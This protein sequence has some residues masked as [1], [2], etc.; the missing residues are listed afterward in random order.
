[1][2]NPLDVAFGIYSKISSSRYIPRRAVPLEFVLR[3]RSEQIPNPKSRVSLS[4]R[5][6][7]LGLNQIRLDWRMNGAERRS[8]RLMFQ[9]LKSEFE[10]LGIGE[11][12]PSEWLESDDEEWPADL[13]GGPHHM[14]TTRMSADPKQGV[15]DSDCRVHGLRN[16]FV[17]GSSVFPTSGYAN[18]TLTIIALAVRLADHLKRD[19]LSTP[20]LV[21]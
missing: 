15:V 18:P 16:L 12:R 17:A 14:G 13:C 4:D 8:M 2:A 20:T 9:F 10:R 1:M 3:V 7:S 5:R 6:D 19:L 11:V 21:G